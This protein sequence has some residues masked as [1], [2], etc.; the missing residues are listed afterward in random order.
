MKRLTIWSRLCFAS[1]FGIYLVGNGSCGSLFWGEEKA[2]SEETKDVE[3]S[4]LDKLFFSTPCGR[5][6]VLSSKEEKIRVTIV[7]R[8][9]A[10]SKI[11]ALA[12]LD[13]IRIVEKRESGAQ[14]F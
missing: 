3:T 13:K 5:I 1:C 7:K 4:R 9:S 2:Y 12:L 14:K 6:E 8:A 10:P 11:E